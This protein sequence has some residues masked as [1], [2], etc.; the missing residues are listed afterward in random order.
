MRFR[1]K[2]PQVF[3]FHIWRSYYLHLKHRK[4]GN[5]FIFIFVVCAR[6]IYD[7]FLSRLVQTLNAFAKQCYCS[8]TKLHADRLPQMFMALSKINVC[9]FSFNTSED[10]AIQVDC[11]SNNG[12]WNQTG[13]VLQLPYTVAC[14][15]CG[16]RARVNSLMCLGTL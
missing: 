13:S 4:I 7:F 10:K 9:F 5:F 8:E 2:I 3:C 11:D 1:C 16:L 14:S 6:K 12:L 15:D